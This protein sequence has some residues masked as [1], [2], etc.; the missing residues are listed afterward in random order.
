MASKIINKIRNYIQCPLCLEKTLY[1]IPFH[2]DTTDHIACQFCIQKI[3]ENSDC[4]VNCPFCGINII[5][6]VDI[7][8][9]TYGDITLHVIICGKKIRTTQIAIHIRYGNTIKEFKQ[10]VCSL[11]NLDVKNIKKVILYGQNRK[12]IDIIEN[13]YVKSAATFMFII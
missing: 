10:K 3:K 11:I 5:D 4:I 8:P 12:D 13:I 9:K 1:L 2:R 6:I 7:Y